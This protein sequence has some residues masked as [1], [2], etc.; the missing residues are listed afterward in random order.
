MVKELSLLN[1]TK[2]RV[3][4]ILV[5]IVSIQGKNTIKQSLVVVVWR[6]V[7]LSI[8]MTENQSILER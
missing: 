1:V 5:N 4:I 8:G 2:G 3:V 7:E 6:N